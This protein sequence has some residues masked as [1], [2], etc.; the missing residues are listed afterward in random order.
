MI[1]SELSY[2]NIAN[3]FI[4]FANETEDK[5]VTNLKLQ[6]LVYYAQAW[7]LANFD[8]P[9]FNEDFQAWIHGPVI[10]KLYREYK[11][12]GSQAIEKQIK[13]KDIRDEFSDEI[14]NFLK[15]VAKI[16]MPYSAYQLETMTHQENP[17]IEVRGDA[18]DDEKCN[19]IINKELIKK[20][21]KSRLNG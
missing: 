5:T 6:K 16:Y 7:Y 2:N 14:F 9:L 3:F 20:F 8:K 21:Y 11:L 10:P 12:N 15:E 4:A 18:E 17:W 19:K 1:N 13:I